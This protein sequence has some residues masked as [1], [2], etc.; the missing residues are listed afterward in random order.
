MKNANCAD[1]ISNDIC[2]ILFAED[3]DQLAIEKKVIF[4]NEKCLTEQKKPIEPMFTFD[5]VE[6]IKYQAYADGIHDEKQ[7]LETKKNIDSIKMLS[8]ID[9]IFFEKE[10][11][12]II[13]IQKSSESISQL[14]FATLSTLLPNLCTRHHP[15]EIVGLVEG[16]MEN[17]TSEPTLCVSVAPEIIDS[18]RIALSILSPDKIRRIVLIPFEDFEIGD[19]KVSWQDGVAHRSVR[20]AQ[21]AVTAILTTLELLPPSLPPHNKFHPFNA[22]SSSVAASLRVQ[23]EVEITNG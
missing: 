17:M 5:Q 7:K 6:E 1:M 10:K 4:E 11:I 20:Q 8:L 15:A 19:A 13:H 22:A 21:D 14:L 2:G 12:S 16:V 18:L 9:K 3:F 23:Q